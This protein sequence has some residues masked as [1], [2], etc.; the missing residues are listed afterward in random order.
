V[1][2]SVQG[3]RGG[4]WSSQGRE[5]CETHGGGARPGWIGA[6]VEGGEATSV[7]G[8]A[9]GLDQGVV[10]APSAG[11]ARSVAGGV[12]GTS[13]ASEPS[14]GEGT[15]TTTGATTTNVAVASAPAETSPV[16]RPEILELLGAY[17]E[18]LAVTDEMPL[19]VP[20][21]TTQRHRRLLRRLPRPRWLLRTI[22]LHHVVSVLDALERRYHLRAALHTTDVYDDADRK[23]V[24]HFRRS[25]PTLHGGRLVALLLI[26]VLVVG[27]LTLA[28]VSM[29]MDEDEVEASLEADGN[30]RAAPPAGAPEE[31]ESSRA[32]DSESDS[33]LH[34][35][36]GDTL[37]KLSGLITFAL[38]AAMLDLGSSGRLLESLLDA[39]PVAFATLVGFLGLIMYVVLRPFVPAFRLKR[40]VFNLHPAVRDY[41]QSTD[42]PWHVT[43]SLGTYHM[44][45]A[46]FQALGQRSPPM[47]RPFDLGVL[48]M[49]AAV[50]TAVSAVVG[51][52]GGRRAAAQ[53]VGVQAYAW[54]IGT[55]LGLTVLLA[56]PFVARLLW[57]FDAW[58]RRRFFS[59][60]VGV[61]GE[62]ALPG[63]QTIILLRRPSHLAI[64]GAAPY[65]MF[66]G[67]LIPEVIYSLRWGPPLREFVLEG[68][69][70]ALFIG[71]VVALLALPWWYRINRE[72]RDLGRARGVDLGRWPG[73]VFA[74]MFTLLGGA[75]LTIVTAVRIRR[76]QE[77]VGTQKLRVPVWILPPGLFV[78]P[79]LLWYLQSQL[80]TVWRAVGR[81]VAEEAPVSA[82]YSSPL[83]PPPPRRRQPR[84]RVL[85]GLAALGFGGLAAVTIEQGPDRFGDDDELDQLWIECDA[86]EWESCELLRHESPPHSAYR[87]FAES[88]IPIRYGDAPDLDTLWDA[89]DDGDGDA[90]VELDNKVWWDSGY[91][92][93]AQRNLPVRYGDA[94][95]L[96]MLL[97]AC[98]ADDGD[99]CIELYR[100][101][102]W[103]SDYLD[104]AEANIPM[105]Y[106][107]APDLDA[108][109]D[110]CNAGDGD[111]C[112][113]LDWTVW[114][115]SDY[116]D[117]AEANLPKRYGDAPSL[118]ALWDACEDG[119]GEACAMLSFIAP[120]DSEY[121]EF[122]RSHQPF[123][124]DEALEPLYEACLP[125]PSACVEAVLSRAEGTR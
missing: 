90:C 103:V 122:G 123:P 9:A 112:V 71:P 26:S 101:V 39:G 18:A 44:E 117:L 87:S 68:L 56:A 105:R 81:P 74:L 110:A 98:V 40:L 37:E 57:L 115:V 33:G 13:A 3:G 5:S 91:A 19:F 66:A 70:G 10:G 116:R 15:A 22:L 61:S 102:W 27:Q 6:S 53:F 82:V 4:V 95:S 94:T 107:D 83:A 34:E 109:W 28:S 88:N 63:T 36:V 84:R 119:A 114:W 41:L 42:A 12:V 35:R 69:V 58:R 20:V 106:G 48:A 59:P 93:L 72:L 7:S 125:A 52:E 54:G 75:Y 92:D 97:D 51:L 55:A 32:D 89:C 60:S 80:N 120:W 113:E 17:Q 31:A 46:T 49:P 64:A 43:R 78:P 76:A 21:R 16:A 2:S 45:A 38:S 121:G 14:A 100:T 25:L 62:I 50:L 29:V 124:D 118:D 1:A 11:I 79:L 47:E 30:E 67:L 23:V 86:G 111:A 8:P 77:V 96:D 108:L 104:V 24:D 65:V 73:L 85:F 99:A